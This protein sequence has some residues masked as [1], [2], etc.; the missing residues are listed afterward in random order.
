MRL[1]AETL[2]GPALPALRGLAFLLAAALLAAW[3][4][5]AE[6]FRIS[7]LVLDISSRG[8]GANGRVEVQNLTGRDL[9]LEAR[10]FAI[11]FG[12]EGVNGE[13][14]ADESFVVFPP[15]VVLKPNQRQVFRIQYVG[16]QPAR[17]RAYHA[18]F[19]QLPVTLEDTPAEGAQVQILYDLRALISVTPPDAAPEVRVVSANVVRGEDGP[20]LE[21]VIRNDGARYASLSSS[22]WIVDGLDPLGRDTRVEIGIASLSEVLGLAYVDAGGGVRRFRLTL[23]ESLAEGEVRLRFAP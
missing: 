22:R 5:A 13:T 16:E 19:R 7:P 1:F 21:A 8:A 12:E 18:S 9:P 10:M 20:V 11:T 3:P 23:P 2:K 14:P 17:S 6:A 4:G 15:Q